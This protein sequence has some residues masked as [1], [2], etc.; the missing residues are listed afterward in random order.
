MYH[1]EDDISIHAPAWGATAQKSIYEPL[2]S[3]FNPRARVGRDVMIARVVVLQ[4]QF[5]S[6]RP[7]GARQHTYHNQKAYLANFNPRAR[8][9]RDNC[10]ARYTTKSGI[11]IHAPAWGATAAGVLDDVAAQISI[12][13]P[14]WGAT[15]VA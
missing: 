1:I 9:G 6:T 11:S 2:S 12:H 5:Q 13:A 14:A 15:A 3:D 4:P 8:V 7:R 10:N